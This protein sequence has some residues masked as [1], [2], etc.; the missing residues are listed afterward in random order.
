MTKPR[1]KKYRPRPVLVN[2]LGYV[3]ESITPVAAHESYL[4]DLRIKN[5]AALAELTQG[6]AT[7][8]EMDVLINASN[9]TDALMRMGFGR[10]YAEVL[11]KGQN[12]L[13]AVAR[14]GVD[15][16]RFVL[17]AEEMNAINTLF[18]LHDAQLD[19]M[20]VKDI[21]R[22]LQLIERERKAKKMT[23]VKEKK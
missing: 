16:N 2:P 5:H 8:R 17:R 3:L 20:V 7:K 9:M 14:R 22:A 18:E 12:A 19:V 4:V 13:L 10:D 11:F 1:K 15:T 6:K 23:P 21:E